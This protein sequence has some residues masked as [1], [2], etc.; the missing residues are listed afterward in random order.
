L[1][2]SS[3]TGHNGAATRNNR[4]A[5]IDSLF[6]YLAL[7]HPE[8]TGDVQRVLAISRKR[9]ERNLLTYLTEPEVH[10]LLTVR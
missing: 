10:A 9:T 2:T 8:H 1:T 4:L 3:A 7:R 6:G 5:A